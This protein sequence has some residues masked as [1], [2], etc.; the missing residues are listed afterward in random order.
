[1]ADLFE[2]LKSQ[3]GGAVMNTLGQQVG[4]TQ[5]QQTENAVNGALSILMNAMANNVQSPNGAQAL[6]AA[7]ERDHDGSILNDLAGFIQ[8]KSQLNQ[9]KAGNGAGILGHLLGANQNSAIETLS[10]MSG[11]STNQS[12][13]MLVKLAPVVLGML[14]KQKK[15]LGLNPADL[16]KIIGAAANTSKKQ[17]PQ[18]DLLTTL[19]NPKKNTQQAN[20][21]QSALTNIGMNILKGFFKK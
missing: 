19:L 11:L 3:M 12:Q 13:N 2:L 6:N 15:T 9:A 18:A 1:M 16:I 17:A 8:G 7:I 14:G 4:T 5:T 21:P 20:N 10:K